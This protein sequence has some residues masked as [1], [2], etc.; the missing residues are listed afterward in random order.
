MTQDT[1]EF[2]EFL[3]ALE[4]VDMP[5]IGRRFTWFHPNGITMSRLDRVLLS[6]DWSE[7]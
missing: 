4:L 6:H 7:T 5:L 1:I 2:G 3:E